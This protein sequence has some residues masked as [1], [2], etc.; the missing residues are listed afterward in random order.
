M[1]RFI[2]LCHHLFYTLS[3][4][5]CCFSAA[6]RFEQEKL[7]NNATEMDSEVMAQMDEEFTQ[8]QQIAAAAASNNPDN[9]TATK[10]SEDKTELMETSVRKPKIFQFSGFNNTVNSCQ[11]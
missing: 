3:P 8:E 5:L 2:L 4:I 7:D 1:A 6:G 9:F 10:D 11:F